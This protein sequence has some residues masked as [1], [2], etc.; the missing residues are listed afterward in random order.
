MFCDSAELRRALWF[1]F[2][3]WIA[4][5]QILTA[6]KTLAPFLFLLQKTYPF[7]F[8]LI[9]FSIGTNSK[10]NWKW[11]CFYSRK[12]QI[13]YQICANNFVVICNV[14]K[15]RE[16]KKMRSLYASIILLY[17]II[18]TKNWSSNVMIANKLQLP[19]AI[20]SITLNQNIIVKSK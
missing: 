9:L 20:L 5:L 11:K 4:G 15:K 3:Q 17:Y 2:R 8:L 13:C 19:H 12:F 14:M 7:P 18:C 1:H 16:E 6:S 10:L